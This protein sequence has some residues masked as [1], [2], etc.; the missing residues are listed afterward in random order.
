MFSL[1]QGLLMIV[2]PQWISTNGRMSIVSLRPRHPTLQKSAFRIPRTE[3]CLIVKD[4]S[5]IMNDRREE[6][7]NALKCIVAYLGRKLTID[8]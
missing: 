6:I 7:L 4:W 1:Q 8:M 2:V 5:K 3:E